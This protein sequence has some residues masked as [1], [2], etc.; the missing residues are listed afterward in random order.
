M[1]RFFL[2]F[3]FFA[4]VVFADAQIRKI[5]AEVTDAFASKYPHATKVEWRDKLQYFEASFQLNG[6]SII[7]D[8][9]SKGEWESS[10]RVLNFND[11]PDEVRDGFLKSKYSD[12][13]KN[14]VA[15]SQ[16]LGKPLQYRINI[17]KS[18]I[19]KKNLYFDTNGKLIKENIAL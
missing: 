16:E 4:V 17:Q 3:V 15:E 7:A 19:Q 14:T 10:E 5:P 2:L 8:F 18:G 12:W 6:S 13:K 1:K 9:S 11:L